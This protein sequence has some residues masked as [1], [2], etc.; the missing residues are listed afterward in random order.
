LIARLI[1]SAAPQTYILHPHE[2]RMAAMESVL[3]EISR[4]R[5]TDALTGALWGR[6]GG[7]GGGPP[8]L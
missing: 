3:R 7:E 8:G 1:A 5:I 2:D 4:R 6:A